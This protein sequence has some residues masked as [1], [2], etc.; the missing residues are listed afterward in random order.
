LR[1]YY[2]QLTKKFPSFYVTR[3][4]ITLL[5][6]AR[7]LPPI[8]SHMNTDQNLPTHL[9]S[10]LILSYLSAVFRTVSVFQLTSLNA[11]FFFPLPCAPH[12]PPISS[13]QHP[14]EALQY[15]PFCSPSPPLPATAITLGI[16]LHF[17]N[18]NSFFKMRRT[19]FRSAA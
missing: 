5:T 8:P 19:T 12:A 1:N 16:M 4:F 9:R 6:T 18:S 15:A 10:I 17:H 3:R 13:Q 7:Y 11:A 2:F 14:N